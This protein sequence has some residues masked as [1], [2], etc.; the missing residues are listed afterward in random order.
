MSIGQKL[1]QV[2][3]AVYEKGKKTQQLEW[4]T[5]YVKALK[6]IGGGSA[7]YGATWNDNTFNPPIDIETI[8]ANGMFANCYIQDL[9]GILARNGVRLIF[10]CSD[11][12]H[13]QFFTV[14]Q[15]ARVKYLPYLKVPT[16]ST[17]YGWFTSCKYLI[18]VDGYECTERHAFETSAGAQKT[19]Q[20]CTELVKIIFH[21]TIAKNCD[22]H[23]STKLSRESILSLLQVL[24]VSVTGVTITLPAKCIDSATDT[25]EYIRANSELATP[26][27]QALTNGYTIAFQ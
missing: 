24:K 8:S 27:E 3:D 6:T 26:F 11:E 10:N 2:A 9:R 21:G 12:I 5:N 1:E 16:T 22:I 14:F 4:W 23:W 13:T 19:F 17:A 7:F 18:E 15:G 25:F 20:N